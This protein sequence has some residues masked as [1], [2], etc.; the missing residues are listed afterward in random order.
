MNVGFTGSRHGMTP[1]QAR[2]LEALLSGIADKGEFHHGDCIGSDAIAFALARDLGYSTVAHP[3][4]VPK[5]RAYTESDV[6]CRTD[7]FLWRNRAIVA[8]T[9]TILATPESGTE[10]RSGTWATIRHAIKRQKKVWIIQQD[11]TAKA[12][13]INGHPPSQ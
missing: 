7:A 6:I 8:A 12:G 10:D 2:T 4:P 9:D 3:G 5:M 13:P 11:G 1:E